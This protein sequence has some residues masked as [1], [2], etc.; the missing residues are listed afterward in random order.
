MKR[1]TLILA[2]R[3]LK[4]SQVSLAEK[5][6]VSQNMISQIENGVRTPSISVAIKI[7]DTLNLSLDVFATDIKSENCS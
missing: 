3:K 7:C 1:T 2:R 6:G 5:V 4:L